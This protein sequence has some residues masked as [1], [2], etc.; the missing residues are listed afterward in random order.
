[1]IGIKPKKESLAELSDLKLAV[2]D[3]LSNDQ[4]VSE[5]LEKLDELDN[6]KKQCREQF[7]K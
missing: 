7:S 3:L 5:A 4:D 2:E 1:M 6:L